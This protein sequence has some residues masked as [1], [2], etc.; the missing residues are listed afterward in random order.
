MTKKNESKSLRK[1]EISISR[2][3]QG[4]GALPRATGPPLYC[5]HLRTTQAAQETFFLT[6]RV[7]R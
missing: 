4:N 5:L 3:L 1:L 2:K 7:D 6:W